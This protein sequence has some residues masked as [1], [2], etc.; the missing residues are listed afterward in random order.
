MMRS[1]LLS[2]VFFFVTTFV[3][4]DNDWRIPCHQGR[5]S[6]EIGGSGS[7][8][9]A[10]VQ[11]VRPAHLAFPWQYANNGLKKLQWGHHHAISD[12]T[13]AGGFVIIR[14]EP[15]LEEQ[16]I[17][18][19]CQDSDMGGMACDHVHNSGAVGTVVRLPDNVRNTIFRD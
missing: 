14:C 13:E 15:H 1:L 11:I 9:A 3:R 17:H 12:I 6:Y 2:T 8:A 19:V 5:C 16:E 7:N 4:A 10:S 18:L